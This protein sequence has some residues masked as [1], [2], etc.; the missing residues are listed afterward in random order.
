M[1][2]GAAAR[3][4]QVTITATIH[5]PSQYCFQLFDGLMMLLNG[6][7][8]YFG[9]RAEL[10]A[11]A[12]SHWTGKAPVLADVHNEAEYIVDIVTAADR[13]GESAAFADQY[14]ASAMKSDVDEKVDTFLVRTPP[15]GPPFI[16]VLRDVVGPCMACEAYTTQQEPAAQ[17]RNVRC[18]AGGAQSSDHATVPERIKAE[19]ATA[20]ETVTPWWFGL[21]T[22]VKYR[23]PRNY[24]DPEFLGPRIGDKIMMSCLMW[25]LYWRAAP[26]RW[27]A[28]RPPGGW[29]RER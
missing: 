8:V 15:G 20:R 27:R 1:T 26:A 4:A 12:Q 19:L 6:R 5:S 23:T 21:K 28:R 24:R 18:A 25:S 22:L 3:R 29:S 16:H 7:V 11:F 9:R 10:M 14:A 17:W 2:Q 13:A